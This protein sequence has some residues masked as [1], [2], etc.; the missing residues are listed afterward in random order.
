MADPRQK[1]VVAALLLLLSS[2]P[3]AAQP[4]N[5][6]PTPLRFTVPETDASGGPGSPA[7]AAASRRPRIGLALAGGGARAAASVGVLKVLRDEGI[8][9]AAIAGTSMG[10]IIG[11]FAA[12][13]HSPDE[14]RRIFLDNDWND[15]FTD[16]PS[17]LFL[18]QAQKEADSRHLLQFSFIGG[19][20]VPPPGLSAGQKLGNLL[21]AQTLAASFQSGFQ[22]DRLPVPFRA[23]ATDIETGS[24][25]V[26]DRGLLHDALRASS[27]IPV[28]FPPVEIEGRLLVDG[29]LAN[30]LPVTVVKEMGADIVIAVDPSSRL[31]RKERLT[32]LL[33]VM[34]QSISIPVR[35]ETGRQALLADVVIAPDI[36]GYS[37][38]DFDRMDGI[39]RAGEDAARAALPAIRR[40]IAARED[41]AASGRYVISTLTVT[42]VVHAREDAVR[43]AGE[44]LLAP[45]GVDRRDIMRVLEAVYRIGVFSDVSLDL[46]GPGPDHRAVI[47]VRENPVVRDISVAG[48]H[49]VPEA[50][51]RAGLAGQL[52]SIYNGIAAAEALER[53]VR[54]YREQGYL[55]VHLDVLR[56]QQDGRTLAVVLSEGRVDDI[57]LDGQKRT[58]PSLI[59]REIRT[60]VGQPLNF[61]I[62]EDDIQHLYGMNIFETLNIGVE[63]SERGGVIVTLR[64]REKPRGNV[65]LGLR[66]D[67]EDAFTG[68][69]DVVVENLGGR[70]IRL[71]VN[72][73]FGNYTDL[74][75]GYLSP[76]LLNTYFVHSLQVFYRDRTYFLYDGSQNRTGTLEVSRTGADLSFGYQWLKFGD[77]YLRYRYER[78]RTTETAGAPSPV[79]K[80]SI[81]SLAFLT[82]IDTRDGAIFPHHG[83]LFKGSYEA[84]SDAYGGS[85]EFRKLDLYGQ[86]A[87]SPAARHTVTIDLSAGFGSGLMPYQEQF[88]IGGADHLLGYPLLGYARREFVGS[89]T[90]GASIAY[91]WMIAD[92]QLKALR[93]VYLNMQAGAA[94]VWDSRDAMTVRDLRGGA[95]IGLHADTLVGPFR[96]D[97]G[98]GEDRRYSVYFS[99]GFDF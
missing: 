61:G 54:R 36:P 6:A 1:A 39:I 32:T 65:R 14:I 44:V 17:R 69:A 81:G 77:T 25:V 55:L 83:V 68:L 16:T 22:F 79:A 63:E 60:A 4:K 12:A 52:G 2:L 11:G 57:R 73:R 37:F 92:Y 62:L 66:Y 24:A 38:S 71:F 26:L 50:E 59:Q 34:D 5:P 41:V 10:A 47:T 67:L 56:M 64:I 76:E 51:I 91:R 18:S 40:I 29:G 82:T 35:R 31:E 89:N 27:A 80:D 95:G 86:A 48:N 98:A 45:G 58:R 13:G 7:G 46:R 30:N 21:A 3:V 74:A 28:V 90:L 75:L 19:R 93:A 49:L 94:N 15:L 53:I 87:L 23:V 97:V 99:A 8:P 78:D 33:G 85:S 72:T 43:A 84:A 70:G 42:G 20:F 96:L 9:V 88:G